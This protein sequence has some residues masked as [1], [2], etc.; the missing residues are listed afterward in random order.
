MSLNSKL[1]LRDLVLCRSE[2]ALKNANFTVLF[3]CLQWPQMNCK[4][5]ANTLLTWSA[6]RAGPRSRLPHQ[7][8]WVLLLFWLL[9]A[10]GCV[11]VP[12]FLSCTMLSLYLNNLLC[13]ISV[14]WRSIL[15]T[16]VCI[17]AWQIFRYLQNS[18]SLQGNLLAC[19]GPG[20]DL[21]IHFYGILHFCS[22]I[23]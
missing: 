2:W 22:I 19:P 3:L 17:S 21:K 8:W 16:Y 7:H 18:V 12:L 14:T 4:E 1:V 5:K 9:S 11:G 23:V 13:T 20:Q 15:T 10:P 6:Q